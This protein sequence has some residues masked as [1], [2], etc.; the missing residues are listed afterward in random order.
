M[1]FNSSLLKIK[2]RTTFLEKKPGA[3]S[4]SWGHCCFKIRW[5]RWVE[6]RFSLKIEDKE[7]WDERHGFRR[8]WEGKEGFDFCIEDDDEYCNAWNWFL[9]FFLLFF[10]LLFYIFNFPNITATGYILFARSTHPGARSIERSNRAAFR[11]L[12]NSFAR[13]SIVDHLFSFFI[14]THNSHD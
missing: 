6:L 14:K 12:L 7:G 1:G 4:D 8:F 5:R 3:K 9:L 2:R 10:L 13:P 11:R